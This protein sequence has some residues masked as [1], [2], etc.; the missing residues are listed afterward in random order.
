MS[1][2]IVLYYFGEKYLIRKEII[3]VPEEIDWCIDWEVFDKLFKEKMKKEPYK[4]KYI[5]V[6]PQELSS[7]L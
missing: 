3:K 2:Y 4:L 1:T 7:Y 5:I 6:K